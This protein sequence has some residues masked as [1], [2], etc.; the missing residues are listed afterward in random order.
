MVESILLSCLLL[1][2]ARGAEP[3]DSKSPT[4]ESAAASPALDPDTLEMVKSFLKTPTENLPAEHIPRFLEVDPKSLPKKLRRPFEAKCV[5]L[6]SLRQVA[7][8]NKR[9]GWR[10]PEENCEVVKEGRS[11][12]AG[13]LILA[14]FLEI[15]EDE[16][17]WLMKETNCTEHDLMCEFTLQVVAEK[18]GKKAP[19][20]RR[21]FLHQRDPVFA[22]ISQYREEGRVRQ[23][24]FF[25]IGGLHCAPRQQ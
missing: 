21:L 6:Y 7:A 14:G 17:L 8:G 15:S 16:E 25:G 3:P 24:K 23:T 1:I 18:A 13:I 9:G 2:P 20:R 5:E 19:A 10:T 11:N 12:S 22:L 4:M